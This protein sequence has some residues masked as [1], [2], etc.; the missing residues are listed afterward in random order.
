M[1]AKMKFVKTAEAKNN[2]S[3]YLAYVRRGGRV[4]ILDRDVPVADLIPIEASASTD[5][6][7]DDEA[8]LASLERRGLVR[9][10]KKGKPASQLLRPG[11]RVKADAVQLL[12][13]D[14]RRER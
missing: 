12:I 4:R 7:L 8:L 1:I 13:D 9:R 2:L 14:R 3:R 5:A 6:P 10:G 11:P